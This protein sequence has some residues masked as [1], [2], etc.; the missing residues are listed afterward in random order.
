[1]WSKNVKTALMASLALPGFHCVNMAE[2]SDL[3]DES[4]PSLQIVSPTG[5][6]DY[7][8]TGSAITLGGTASDDCLYQ[9]LW[10]ATESDESGLASASTAWDGAWHWEVQGIS[11]VEGEN[12]IAVIAR[13]VRG[14]EVFD[15]LTVTKPAPPPPPPPP[16][17]GDGDVTDHRLKITVYTDLGIDRYNMVAMLAVPSEDFVLPCDEDVTVTA[18]AQDPDDPS[19]EIE[20]F[21]D[22]IPKGTASTC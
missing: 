18:W 22:R 5:D 11:L 16:P 9:I 8:T 13:D 3:C 2:A 17:D 10:S 4:P 19:Q 12:Q 7:E 1:M 15:T 14:N 21:S 20:L 6:S